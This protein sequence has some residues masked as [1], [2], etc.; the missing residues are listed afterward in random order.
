MSRFLVRVSLGAF[1]STFLVATVLV[2]CG[3][4]DH[5]GA[6]ARGYGTSSGAGGSCEMPNEG[7]SCTPSA[8][9]DCGVELKGDDSFLWC[10]QGLRTCSA[11]GAWGPCITTGSMSVRSRPEDV[12][13]ASTAGEVHTLALGAPTNCSPGVNPCDPYC[14]LQSDT[15][16]GLDGGGAF[17]LSEGGLVAGACGNGI[18]APPEQCDDGNNASGDGC[19]SSCTIE[20][21][22]K[23]TA[24]GMPCTPTVCGDNVKEGAEQCDDGNVRPY[25]GCS[26]TCTKEAACVTGAGCA[27]ICG[28]GLK[29][30]S[31]QCDDGNTT[32]GDGCS[33]TCNIEPGATCAVVTAALPATITVPILYR[34]FTPATNPDFEFPFFGPGSLATGVIPGIAQTFLA[35]D[36]EPILNTTHGAVT[37]AATFNEWYRDTADNKV[38]VDTLTLTKQ[39]DNSY[40]YN[41]NLGAAVPYTSFFPIDGRGFGNY[42]A[43]GHNYSFTSEL[44]YP[45]TY[46]GNE[47]LDFLG[48]DDVFVFINGRLAVDLGGAHG[49]STGSITL[50]PAVAATFGLTVGN[51]YRLD[52]F[53]AERHSTGSSYKL[54]LR[55]F[56]Q[57]LSQCSF[58]QGTFV[59][60]FEAKCD[61]GFA[62][63]WQLFQWK[64]IVPLLT[65]IDFRAATA[66]T[67]AALPA[68]PPATSPTTVPIGSANALNSPLLGPEVFQNDVDAMLQPV[69][70]S[71]HLKAE[72]N[73][74][75]KAWL[76]VYMTFNAFA[77]LSPRLDAWRQ[78]YDCVPSE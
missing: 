12:S 9:A 35:A 4:D 10:A 49:P 52:V 30:P 6:A 66:A 18:L 21:G 5:P 62:P 38:I 8:E 19:S 71:K 24:P 39:P 2:A 68:A 7:C 41:S 36:Q 73:T 50:T 1:A 74:T 25:D 31:E 75:S 16:A 13:T 42:A 44:R 32:D 11:T 70:V 14:F 37:S 15:P 23:C 45:F 33:S 67:Q 48:D 51:T 56:V 61:P 26:P 64:A 65:S 57:A 69:P 28:D 77:V 60:D 43:T 20:P 29:F 46:Q 47:V 59:R 53:Q 27:A 76:R 34:D 78:L 58:P 3:A 22:F 55:G 54:T 63:V 17:G 40:V 72:G